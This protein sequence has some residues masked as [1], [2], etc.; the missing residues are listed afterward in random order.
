MRIFGEFII[1]QRKNLSGRFNMGTAERE[2]EKSNS[3]NFD[4]SSKECES[5]EDSVYLIDVPKVRVACTNFKRLFNWSELR[6]RHP[7]GTNSNQCGGFR[8]ISCSFF[9]NSEG[10]CHRHSFREFPRLSIILHRPVLQTTLFHGRKVLPEPV[11]ERGQI[12][13][14]FCFVY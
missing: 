11:F 12:D 3:R 4:Q 13:F 5:L 14:L 2:I 10:I 8:L 7:F 6:R 1:H 9:L